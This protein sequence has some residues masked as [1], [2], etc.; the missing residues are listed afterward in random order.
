[1]SSLPQIG[2]LLFDAV[3]VL[4]FAGPLE[5]LQ[6]P[7]G[8]D[9]QPVFEVNTI[10]VAP[11]VKCDGG[12][13][14]FP[15]VEWQKAGAMDVLVVPGGKGARLPAEGSSLDEAVLSLADKADL[16]ASVCTGSFVLAR[17]GLLNG[18]TATTHSRF[19]DEFAETFPGIPLSKEKVVE[20]GK[21]ITAG[22]IASG[23]DLA[24]HLIKRFYGESVRQQA[25]SLLDGPWK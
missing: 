24:L 21:M 20:S 17:T 14:V 25:C 9:G 15:E 4:D 10:G 3:E 7:A 5:V 22:G 16:V 6:L 13:K 18:H 8:E 23:I 19:M 2:M 1:M 12:L 11:Q